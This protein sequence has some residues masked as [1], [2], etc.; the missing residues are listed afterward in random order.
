MK[1]FSLQVQGKEFHVGVERAGESISVTVNG[2]KYSVQAGKNKSSTS[3][4]STPKVTDDSEQVL[5]APMTGTIASIPIMQ[6]Q[7]VKKGSTAFVLLAM[8]MHN[9]IQF[10]YDGLVETIFV[11]EG[12]VIE[13]GT[14]LCLYQRTNKTTH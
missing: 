8:K 6:G 2:K 9:E 14:A 7:Q 13:K 5:I 12:M 1:K 4:K 3:L 10:D 11:Q